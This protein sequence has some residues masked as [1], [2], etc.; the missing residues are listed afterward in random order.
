MVRDTDSDETPDR[1]KRR[2]DEEVFGILNDHYTKV[3]M[4]PIHTV[5]EWIFPG[6]LYQR[7]GIN[8]FLRI[9]PTN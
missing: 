8:G 4:E 2:E 3:D 6:W 5:S 1:L 9:I 7:E